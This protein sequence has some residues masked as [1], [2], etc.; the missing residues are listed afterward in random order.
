MS[1]IFG[2]AAD[3]DY[4]A[5]LSTNESRWAPT[6]SPEASTAQ[7]NLQSAAP[8]AAVAP[9]MPPAPMPMPMP[10]PVPAPLPGARPPVA[11]P[12]GILDNV[13][14]IL[15][16]AVA[17]AAIVHGYKRNNDSIGWALGWGALGYLFWWATGPI[18]V[19]QGFAK[20]AQK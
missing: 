8:Q 18:M 19:A 2:A 15:R 10:A 12:E 17:M 6:I 4:E 20:P 14:P 13:V 1:G 3:I 11:K 9:F 16:P 7:W 5:E